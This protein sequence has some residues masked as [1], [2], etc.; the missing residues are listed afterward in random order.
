MAKIY[1]YLSGIYDA[2]WSEFV[3]KY[4]GLL[5][6]LITENN[7]KNPIIL[8]LAC[9]TGVLVKALGQKGY[10]AHGIDLTPQMID[11]ARTNTHG[12]KEV[13]FE[14]GDMADFSTDRQYNIISC[15]YD[16]INYLCQFDKIHSMFCCVAKALK[17]GG[18]FVFDS[19]CEPTYIEHNG[20][21]FHREI[22]GETF[23]QSCT[24]DENKKESIVRFDFSN[25]TIE[26]H[27]QRPYN[28]IELQPLLEQA[29][30]NVIETFSKFDRTAY[31][32]DSM[33]L[34]C[35]S[36]KGGG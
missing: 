14:V 30:L 36:R 34:F 29:G 18:L 23:I 8:D 17:K 32:A 7:I 28:L 4:I 35:F 9:G 12:I 26:E 11:I 19:N 15:T 25:G 31:D 33:R 20:K 22:N 10:E 3:G 21:S 24:Y 13:S 16:S 2:G 5:D 27:F 6:R 1:E